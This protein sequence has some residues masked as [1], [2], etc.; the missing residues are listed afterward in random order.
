V[1]QQQ[2][3]GPPAKAQPTPGGGKG[4]GK[5]PS[6]E[7]TI[8]PPKAQMDSQIHLCFFLPFCAFL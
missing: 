7:A 5:K 6:F 2:K 1:Q 8:R 3:Q 4:K